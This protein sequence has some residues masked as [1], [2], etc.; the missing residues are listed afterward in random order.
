MILLYEAQEG[1]TQTKDDDALP[2]SDT[3][4]KEPV[5]WDVENVA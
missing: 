5:G 1:K 2:Q 4:D 3:E